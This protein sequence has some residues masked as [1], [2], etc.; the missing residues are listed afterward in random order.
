MENIEFTTLLSQDTSFE[1]ERNDANDDISIST[2][3]QCLTTSAPA[4]VVTEG[5]EE[6]TVEFFNRFT[7]SL[8]TNNENVIKKEEKTTDIDFVANKK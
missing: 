2:L 8:C 5:H 4:A 3:E 7:E 1:M 6:L